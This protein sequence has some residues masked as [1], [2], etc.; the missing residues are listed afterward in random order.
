MPET[1]QVYPMYIAANAM[2]T[3]TQKMK[4]EISK[5]AGESA[6]EKE[7]LLKLI[8]GE[9]ESIKGILTDFATGYGNATEKEQTDR[10][11]T[12]SERLKE[13]F[14]KFKTSVTAFFQR[15]D[16]KLAF[17]EPV[18]AKKETEKMLK[19]YKEDPVGKIGKVASELEKPFVKK[20]VEEQNQQIR[21]S[22]LDSFA[23]GSLTEEKLKNM[24]DE[25]F[26]KT[27]KM[28][29]DYLSKVESLSKTNELPSQEKVG[30]QRKNFRD[31]LDETM[32]QW[33]LNTNQ[34]I[35]S[36][37]QP[38][39]Q[40]VVEMK[41]KM[42]QV[43]SDKMLALGDKLNTVGLNIA[44]KNT[45]Q[46]EQKEAIKESGTSNEVAPPKTEELESKKTPAVKTDAFNKYPSF[47]LGEIAELPK[48]VIQFDKQ[49]TPVE[50][51]N[52]R[53]EAANNWVETKSSKNY[54]N[55]N[56]MVNQISSLVVL[57]KQ[58]VEDMT[59][60][61]NK[62]AKTPSQKESSMQVNK[63]RESI[64]PDN[65]LI[66]K[67]QQNLAESVNILEYLGSR[68]EQFKVVA[69]G[70]Y[71]HVDHDNLRY[72][73]VAKTLTYTS[74][75]EKQI[76]QN[77]VEAGKLLYGLNNAEAVEDIMKNVQ[78][79]DLVLGENNQGKEQSESVKT[80]NQQGL[81]T[82]NNMDPKETEN[83]KA[84][85]DYV[86]YLSGGKLPESLKN[87]D[88]KYGMNEALSMRLEAI[89]EQRM[90]GKKLDKYDQVLDSKVRNLEAVFRRGTDEKEA[91]IW[92]E[93]T[94]PIP[95]Q[96]IPQQ[97]QKVQQNNDLDTLMQSMPSNGPAKEDAIPE[98]QSF[99]KANYNG[100]SG[101]SNEMLER[102]DRE[103]GLD[104]GMKLRLEA[105]NEILQ[106]KGISYTEAEY[107]ENVKINL[108]ESIHRGSEGM[109]KFK[110]N[111]LEGNIETNMHNNQEQSVMVKGIR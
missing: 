71:Q 52:A 38:V 83:I 82:P 106:D 94:T 18:N 46:S 90:F 37:I 1:K 87:F 9:L 20:E 65:S 54:T 26:S 31:K 86:K 61:I 81:S 43:T 35:Q 36:T 29:L 98:Y 92:N 101:S 111:E 80:N 91:F 47:V 4:D 5:Q 59:R 49:Y 88:Q 44:P 3:Q 16:E 13:S 75:G 42:Q 2:E 53:I 66:H 63:A 104:E 48:E 110:E 21:E 95:R 73:A 68:G 24:L 62:E 12:F 15:M 99:M 14:E 79:G 11:Q 25:H 67:K 74:D 22:A 64:I 97:E 72:S 7:D 69:G 70:V 19:S 56:K 109:Q 100:E 103:Y 50:A 10:M 39:Q 85:E 45:M 40:K 51:I 102:Y 84:K 107:M 17:K 78:K 93:Y 41:E 28:V 76:A 60:Y 55:D 33:K 30:D 27:E 6:V 8:H 23:K 34:A 89:E 96:N 57:S 77:A 32:S 58:K 105:V 108:E